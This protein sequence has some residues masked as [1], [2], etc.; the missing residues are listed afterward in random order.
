MKDF[1]ILSYKLQNTN[2]CCSL[3]GYKN[4]EGVSAAVS[5]QEYTAVS[6][7]IGHWNF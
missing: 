1:V 3:L 6:L 4:D 2:Y 5:F 7:E